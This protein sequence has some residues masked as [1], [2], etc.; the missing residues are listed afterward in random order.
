MHSG[1]HYARVRTPMGVLRQLAMIPK[2]RSVWTSP[3]WTC[4]ILFYKSFYIS[5]PSIYLLYSIL[6]YFKYIKVPTISSRS[7]SGPNHKLIFFGMGNEQSSAAEDPPP[8]ET[9]ALPGTERAAL[10]RL[11]STH[12][13]E[14]PATTPTVTT[15]S[16]NTKVSTAATFFQRVW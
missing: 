3:P 2:N 1:S 8:P 13:S 6:I 5:F 15:T 11:E 12:R 7:E 16:V 14:E 10:R 4:V 9:G